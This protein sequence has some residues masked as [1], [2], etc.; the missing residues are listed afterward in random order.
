MDETQIHVST[1]IESEAIVAIEGLLGVVERELPTIYY[2]ND[3]VA[4]GINLLSYIGQH[5]VSANERKL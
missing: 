3:E 4:R 1:W 2:K 5:G